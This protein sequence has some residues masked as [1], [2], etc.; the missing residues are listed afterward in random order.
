[1]PWD[2]VVPCGFI[3]GSL[4][5]TGVLV[6]TFASLGIDFS[7]GDV[8]VSLGNASGDTVTISG[9]AG[10]PDGGMSLSMIGMAFGGLAMLRRRL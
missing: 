9:A 2:L 8:V 3:S 5:G 1:M 4:S 6:G 7:A 10:V